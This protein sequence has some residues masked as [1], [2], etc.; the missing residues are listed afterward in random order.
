MAASVTR[1]FDVRHYKQ[2]I[3]LQH[4][5]PIADL[6]LVAFVVLKLVGVIDWSWWWVLSPI[7][8]MLGLA[9][10]VF[11]VAYIYVTAKSIIK[12]RKAIKKKA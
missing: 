9:V 8:I 11:V 1:G 12:K 5:V 3:E 6:F 10:L 2:Y 7:W 4:S